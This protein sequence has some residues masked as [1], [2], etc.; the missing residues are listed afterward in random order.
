VRLAVR[1]FA[2]AA[3]DS[4]RFTTSWHHVHGEHAELL[5]EGIKD[6]DYLTVLRLRADLEVDTAALRRSAHLGPRA[7]LMVA[8]SAGSSS[9]RLRGSVWTAPV[10]SPRR[11]HLQIEFEL[12]GGELGGRLDLITQVVVTDP[13]PVDEL[14][15][16]HRGAI[17]WRDRH[18]V[19]L[20]GDASQFPTET[21]DLS[22]APY[23]LPKAA[24]L[25]DIVTD[26]LDVAAAA[27]VRLVVNGA[28]PVMR[29][30]LDG[31]ASAEAVLALEAMRWDV[32]RQLVE[33]A[34]SAPEFVER[35]E[36]FEEDSFGWLLASVIATHFPGQSPRSLQALRDLERPRFEA[37][38]Q[39]A[40]RALG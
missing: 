4:V 21:A 13:D 30:V 9:T 25:L 26:D 24:W 29:K 28:H 15:A 12:A 33:T 20:E 11:E 31:D 36:A 22:A 38:L 2:V 10:T 39:D 32:A 19:L 14:G 5:G 27:A 17:I 8:V 16:R 23:N 1:P 18:S 37:A 6:W 35:D 34:L 40:A 7:G 3:D